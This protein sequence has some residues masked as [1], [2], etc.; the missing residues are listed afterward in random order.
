MHQLWPEE[1]ALRSISATHLEVAV[2]IDSLCSRADP[3]GGSSH[4]THLCAA[5]ERTHPHALDR[6]IAD[7]GL[8]EARTQRVDHLR[9]HPGGHDRATD[10][11][12]L[13]PRLRRHLAHDLFDEEVEL[14]RAGRRVRTKDRA[15]QR[16]RFHVEA[17]RVGRDRLAR[18]E[19]V[20]C[21][22]RPG[23]GHR[24]LLLHMIQQIARAPADQL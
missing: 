22:G 3:I 18:L 21:R 13:L 8:R 24:I 11:G 17:H 16:V 1:R 15:V 7:D 20:A 5:R 23:E 6:R 14:L 12:A 10:R 4:S 9:F 2:A 19:H